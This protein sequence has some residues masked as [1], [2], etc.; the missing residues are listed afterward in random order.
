MIVYVIEEGEYS[1]RHVVAVRESLDDAK[2]YV[3]LKQ[4]SG[5][6][7]RETYVISSF[8]TEGA[9]IYCKDAYRIYFFREKIYKVV[10]LDDEEDYLDWCEYEDMMIIHADSE[11]HAK[12]IA[13]D[14]LAELKARKEGIV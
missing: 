12:K 14:K 13:Y 2:K 8:D 3:E 7:Y 11:E 9:I 10:K 5:R 6:G 4:K 1:D